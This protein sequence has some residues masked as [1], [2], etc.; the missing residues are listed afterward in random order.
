MTVKFLGGRDDTVPDTACLSLP[1]DQV[2]VTQQ[3]LLSI[4]SE[5]TGL[6]RSRDL[7]LFVSYDPY[8][9]RSSDTA[10]DDPRLM[11]DWK[12]LGVV[13]GRPGIGDPAAVHLERCA[14]PARVIVTDLSRMASLGGLGM[15]SVSV[16]PE[17]IAS[18]IARGYLDWHSPQVIQVVLSGRLS[19]CVTARDVC[20]ELI[21][22]GVSERVRAAS[23]LEQSPVVLEFSGP[24]VRSLSV[25]DRAQLCGIAPR[26]GAASAVA[27]CDEKT[28]LFLR[29]QRR[30]KAYRQLVSDA[31]APCADVVCLDLSSVSPLVAFGANEIVTVAE[32]TGRPIREV[33]IGGATSA[34]LRDLLNAVAW[35][36]TKRISSDVDVIVV[37][38]TRQVLECLAMTGAL[39]QLL[40]FGVRLL[41]PDARLL[42]GRWH[43]P[44]TDATSLR[45]FDC[46]GEPDSTPPQ[47]GLA[48]IETLCVSAIAG[49]L[50]DPRAARK[51]QRVACPRELPVDDSL[52]FDRKPASAATLP[53][54]KNSDR[55]GRDLALDPSHEPHRAQC[56]LGEPRAWS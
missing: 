12:R 56:L 31:G 24:G 49:S 30:S 45:S 9:V 48:S 42:D 54:P 7:D 52:L 4:S 2:A 41:E 6:E 43:P 51:S 19:A 1:V 28:E 11:A 13:R 23:G 55:N 18:V 17:R 37:P 3:T 53:P 32:A 44:P 34:T 40:A 35:F 27:A 8:C 36:K 50:Q 14:A 33:V 5:L 21:R 16:P 15:L 38:A 25:A 26:V 47:W 39:A 20:L 46:L 22:L 29:D 10:A